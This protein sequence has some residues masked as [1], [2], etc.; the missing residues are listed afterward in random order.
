MLHTLTIAAL[1]AG[2][3]F[4][5]PDEPAPRPAAQQPSPMVETT[6]AHER[7]KSEVPT[8]RREKLALGTLFLP[9]PLP[10]DRLV[11]L[12]VHFHG[13]AWLAE[14]AAVRQRQAVIAVL[15]G[16]GSAAYGKPF[17]DTGAFARLLEE[18]EQKSGRKFGPIVLTAWSAGYGAVRAILRVPEHFARVQG[19]V[20]LDSLH[21]G[22]VD[23]KPGPKES[24]LVEADLEVFVRF[25]RAAA[26]G[27]KRMLVTHSEVFP[28]TFASTTE[29]ADHLLRELKLRRKAIL[30]WGPLGMQQLS[31]AGQGNFQLA[32]FAGNSAPDHVDHL[33]ALP[34]FLGRLLAGKKND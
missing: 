14:Q 12:F 27:T 11:P 8:G 19:V 1:F 5:R 15:L 32:G 33:H 26:E 2:G 10:T 31:E 6:R 21:A 20:L 4:A 25:A 29:T 30:A 22:Y 24:K 28:G 3:P 34:D 23:G 16:T 9:E 17:A 7:L 18:A 13:P